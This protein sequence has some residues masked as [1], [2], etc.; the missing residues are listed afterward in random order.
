MLHKWIKWKLIIRWKNQWNYLKLFRNI[1]SGNKFWILA[2]IIST[3][4]FIVIFFGT[5]FLFK[6][7]VFNE[8]LI[9]GQFNGILLSILWK[10][11]SY[12]S[13]NYEI[14]WSITFLFIFLFSLITGISSSKW[15]IH[16]IDKDW[17]TIT[18]KLSPTK[19][20][21]YLYLE[22][23]TWYTKDYFCNHLPV[24]LALGI[25][26]EIN[27]LQITLVILL[28]FFLFIFISLITSIFHN[29]Y[30]S[31]QKY[32]SNYLFKVIF[33][34]SLRVFAIYIAFWSGKSIAPWIKDF[35]LTSNDLDIQVYQEWINQGS[36]IL[37]SLFSPIF[38]VLQHPFL[39]QNIL[40]MILFD[41]VNVFT[42]LIFT[43]IVF[44]L[45][46]V[47]VLLAKY[48]DKDFEQKYYPF[49]R[50]EEWSV[51]LGN[52]LG[53]HYS[54]I[55]FKHQFRTSYFF[56]RFQTLMGSVPFW[57]QLGVFSGLL[58]GI[59]PETKIYFLVLSFYL[60]FFVFFYVDSVF[61]NLLG[62]FSL[63][64]E[65][66]HILIHLLAGQTLWELFKYKFRLFIVLTFP[67]LLIGD[68]IFL[69]FNQ[70]EIKLSLLIISLHSVAYM[71]FSIILFLPSVISP[72]F[73][74]LNIEQ[75]DEFPDKKAIQDI[76]KFSML[77][78]IIPASMLPTAFLLTDMI[79]LFNYILTQ[80]LFMIGLFFV[81]IM[82]SLR[83]I[84][85]R[86]TKISNI[87]QLFL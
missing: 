46:I 48:Q 13:D 11:L 71:L 44:L 65:G 75:I 63:D 78:I 59:E 20:R 62:I 70:V 18:L 2:L 3:L 8:N 35:P 32:K 79:T 47:A 86:L 77:G 33:N 50:L 82:I 49:K 37:I 66:K 27:W 40:T 43:T 17:L 16:S 53:H 61:T 31:L 84:Q 73:N 10:I 74:Y 1:P 67:L 64:S 4:N 45:S 9:N 83:F 15:Q 28:A 69:I 57:I 72:H 87:D 26:T 68:I 76:I 6:F 22:S 36:D 30:L 21:I 60:F 58:S 85:L 80:W 19:T 39:P 23:I 5:Y 24:L 12:V 7:S 14:L 25:L 54:N 34:V 81:L 51:N 29:R 38:T 56:H 52:L 55:L 42:L 41:N